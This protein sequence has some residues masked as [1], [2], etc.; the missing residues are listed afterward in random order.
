MKDGMR[1]IKID[2]EKAVVYDCKNYRENLKFQYIYALVDASSNSLFKSLSDRFQDNS[3]NCLTM[4]QAIE[5]NHIDKK[6]VFEMLE[7]FKKTSLTITARIHETKK[8][9]NVLI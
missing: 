5:K 8:K 1:R 7:E 3:S 6:N 2:T 9:M 4:S